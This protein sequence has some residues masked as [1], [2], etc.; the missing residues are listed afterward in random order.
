[1]RLLFSTLIIV[2]TVSFLSSQTTVGI[3]SYYAPGLDGE[4]TSSGE[5]YDHDGFTCAN[6]DYPIGSIL[7]VI[8]A[9]DSRFVDV[10]VNDCGPHKRGRVVDLSG[11]AAEQIGLI[12][13]GITQVRIELVRLGKGRLAC[14]GEYVPATNRP[15]SYDAIAEPPGTNNTTAA[16]SPAEPAGI[17]GQG[18]FRA[19]ALRPIA[20]GF[21]VQV[22]SFRV[23]E[24]ASKVAADLQAKGY[25]KVLIRLRGNVHQVVLGPFESREAAAVYRDNLLRKYK[26]RGFVTPL[27]QEE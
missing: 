1:M 24:N 26:L 16:R 17:E 6:K 7:R 22:G 12:R 15:A 5:R 8:R 3:A 18:T 19:E 27:T 10:R 11:A 23:Y 25:S 20:D 2:L 14:G 9:D 4:R 21:G 13:D